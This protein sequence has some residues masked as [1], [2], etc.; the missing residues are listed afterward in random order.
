VLQP[1]P[2]ITEFEVAFGPKKLLFSAV[3][4]DKAEKIVQ[5]MPPGAFPTHHHCTR[6]VHAGS[7]VRTTQA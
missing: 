4:A 3:D 2:G 6:T 7:R 1:Y 5:A